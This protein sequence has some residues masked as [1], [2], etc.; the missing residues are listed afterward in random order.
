MNHFFGG[1]VARVIYLKKNSFVVGSE[2][3]R[4]L[5][6]QRRFGFYYTY[7][8]VTAF[9]VASNIFDAN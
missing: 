8:F 3:K 9:A 4:W 7:T 6:L 2:N 5:H 1:G